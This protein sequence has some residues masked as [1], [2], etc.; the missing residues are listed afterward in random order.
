L[1]STSLPTLPNALS[2][3]TEGFDQLSSELEITKRS[4]AMPRLVD[5][6]P[7]LVLREAALAIALVALLV[8]IATVV[9]APLAGPASPTQPDNP[10]KAPW[11]F[12]GMQEMVSYSAWSGAVLFPLLLLVGLLLFPLLDRRGEHTGR[13]FADVGWPMALCSALAG[14]LVAGCG[15]A[16]WESGIPSLRVLD[17]A[18]LVLVVSILMAVAGSVVRRRWS[19]GGAVLVAVLLGGYLLFT[20]VGIWCRGPFWQ[21]YWPWQ[22]WVAGGTP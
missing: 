2:S 13:W 12:I 7:H 16:L 11:Y 6:W 15:L 14:I 20:V 22:P 9:D 18:A 19:A 10:E 3:T 4:P 17:P 5:A 8:T 1:T 21:F